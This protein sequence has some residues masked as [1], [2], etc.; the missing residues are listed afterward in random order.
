[1]PKT[2]TP[3][4]RAA[5]ELVAQ[6]LSNAEVALARGVSVNTIV[7]QLTSAY[8]KLR[9]SGR[10]EL[11]AA[12]SPSPAERLARVNQ[13]HRLSPREQQVLALAESGYANKVIAPTVGVGI[14]TVSTTLTRA[15]RKLAINAGNG[16]GDG[17][18]AQ[19]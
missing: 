7:N 16:A 4:E 5:I 15:R 17:T 3:S 1:V 6:G 18:A 14:S 12:S 13:Q 9:V 10:R 8:R 2:L 19:R 11:R